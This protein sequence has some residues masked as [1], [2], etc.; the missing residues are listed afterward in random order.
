[1][2]ASSRNLPGRSIDEVDRARAR[3][4]ALLATLLSHSPDA[5]LLSGLAGLHIDNSPIGLAHAALAEAARQATE[6]SVAHEYVAL[7]GG[8]EGCALLPYASHYL[9]DT[10]YGR[11]LARIREMLQ[12]LGVEK[13]PER[14]EPED[15]ASF[16]CEVMAGLV[17][18]DIFAPDGAD[19]IF[20]EEHLASWI[21][22]FFVDLEGTKSASF[23]R[24]VG[25][26]GRTFI[27]VETHAFTLSG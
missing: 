24:S 11:P 7:F 25:I 8:L 9:A 10:L 27:D 3:E 21:R 4:Y 6:E 19:R 15:H 16:L 17:G 2:D 13:A 1:M 18:G 12:P 5:Q 23:Y 20:F 26:L 22:R 14:I